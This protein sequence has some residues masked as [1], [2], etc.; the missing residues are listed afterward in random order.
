M[1]SAEEFV[2]VNELL[3]AHLKKWPT[4]DRVEIHEYQVCI[5]IT[6]LDIA[7]VH[8]IEARQGDVLLYEIDADYR[9]RSA[10]G[11]RLCVIVGKDVADCTFRDTE[12]YLSIMGDYDLIFR[13]DEPGGESYLI[14]SSSPDIGI[15]AI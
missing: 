7:C 14:S 6:G 9:K 11:F 1:L 10:A 12:L 4:I 3:R 13:R 8:K 5:G 2:E 15:F